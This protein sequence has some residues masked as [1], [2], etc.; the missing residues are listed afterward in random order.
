M[1]GASGCMVSSCW[2]YGSI[3]SQAGV[4]EAFDILIY[5]MWSLNDL[6]TSNWDFFS[7]RDTYI[8]TTRLHPR[9]GNLT[10]HFLASEVHD[11]SV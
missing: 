7:E 10:S 1:G 3:F 8:N 9:I 5:C 6:T 11:T 2:S 4:Q